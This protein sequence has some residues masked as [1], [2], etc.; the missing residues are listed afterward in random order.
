MKEIDASAEMW[1]PLGILA[2]IADLQGKTE[3]ARDYRHREHEAYA[4]YPGHHLQ[5]KQVL[6]QV[7][8]A[9]EQAKSPLGQYVDIDVIAASLKGDE[10]MRSYVEAALKQLE[11]VGLNITNAIRRIWAGERDWHSLTEELNAPGALIVL[12]V[13]EAV[14]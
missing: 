7:K 11:G 5:M 1:S 10:Q 9:L 13:L 4:N 12:M 8:Q 14:Q 3:E 2:N 6:E